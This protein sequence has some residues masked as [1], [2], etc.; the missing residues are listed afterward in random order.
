MKK[1]DILVPI[2]PVLKKHRVWSKQLEV[3]IDNR[4]SRKKDYK[5][6]FDILIDR[7]TA[8]SLLAKPARL[9]DLLKDIKAVDSKLILKVQLCTAGSKGYVIRLYLAKVVQKIE[10]FIQR[11]TVINTT[12]LKTK[13]NILLN[14]GVGM[15]IE[16]LHVPD[17]LGKLKILAMGSKFIKLFSQSEN[18]TKNLPVNFFSN[19]TVLIIN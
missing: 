13:N 2:N 19:K 4:A 9:T 1:E 17:S 12:G 7:L 6:K 14:V 3:M 18:K 16:I 8:I 5:A 11:K 15:S 10:K